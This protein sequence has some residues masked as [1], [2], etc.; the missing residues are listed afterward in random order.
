MKT[1]T[2]DSPFL[3]TTH[4]HIDAFEIDNQTNEVFFTGMYGD[5]LTQELNRISLSCSFHQ[6]HSL[7]H[8]HDNELCNDLIE[9]IHDHFTHSEER[10]FFIDICERGGLL[11]TDQIFTFQLVYDAEDEKG[12]P[13][14]PWYY[15]LTTTLERGALLPPFLNQVTPTTPRE[16]MTGYVRLL[17]IQY[18][19]YRKQQNKRSEAIARGIANLSDPLIFEMA[20]GYHGWFEEFTKE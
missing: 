16:K 6:F 1:K 19:V 3:M 18:E 11:F 13:T 14:E 5:L 7:L 20:K 9:Q 4:L 15:A 2:L 17:A 12:E 8:I 10:H